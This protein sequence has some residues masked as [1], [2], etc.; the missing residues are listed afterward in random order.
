MAF[1]P[2][3]SLVT[4]GVADTARSRDFYE[5]LGLVAAAASQGDVAFFQLTNGMALALFPRDKL[6]EDATVTNDGVGFDGVTL[7]QNVGSPAE[8]DAVLAEAVACGARLVKPG[9]AV[10]WGG[11]SGY[12]ADPDGH[13]WEIAHNPFFPLDEAGHL[14]LE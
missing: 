12:F 13:L 7:A 8:V 2:R 3:L 1:A 9:Q 10:F 6:A 4:L 11:Y 14:S 5:R